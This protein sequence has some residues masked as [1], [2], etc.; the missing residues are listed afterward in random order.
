MGKTLD[1]VALKLQRSKNRVQLIYAFNGVGKTR[2]SR[3]FREQ[4]L[5]KESAASPDVDDETSARS[6]VLYYNAFTEDLFYWDN[7]LK[8]GEERVLKIQENHFS[9]WILGEQGQ[10]GNIV[11]HFQ[12]YTSEKL[13]PRFDPSFRSVRFSRDGGN[14]GA[15]ENIKISKG[16]ESCFIWCFFYSLLEQ[17]IE[18]RNEGDVE[19]AEDAYKYIFIDD[20]VSSL[21]E[22]HL[23]EIACDIARL[24]KQDASKLQFIITTHNPL[25]FNV[26]VHEL[27]QFK[28]DKS[29]DVKMLVNEL[30]NLDQNKSK[31]FTEL[32]NELLQLNQTKPEDVNELVNG[33][34]NL[35]QNKSEDFNKLLN[36][37][38]QLNQTKPE[39]VKLKGTTCRVL[40]LLEDGTYEV[41]EN[42]SDHPF[43]YHLRLLK[44]IEQAIDGGAIQKY[45]YA[46][47]RNI[48]E[49]TSVF[50]GHKKWEDLLPG[51]DEDTRN[52]YYQ[53]LINL[54]HHS[55]SSHEE[56]HHIGEGDKRVL[57]YLVEHLKREYKF[58]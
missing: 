25:F 16:E 19:N 24:I 39:D 15:I 14:E 4:L 9:D 8:K 10:D 43:S 13:T 58:R 57:S 2:L 51:E 29:K 21:D 22:N 55:Y 56:F 7:D 17:I 12:R 46:F 45:H 20:P 27:G 48:L 30:R 41:E 3:S 32:L 42:T 49:K 33:L 28:Q 40:S 35:V 36:K 23:I 31:G 44:E 1:E 47:L 38:L 11:K 18:A 37:L 52:A 54:A 5:A 53:R 6:P 26:L 50:L 34:R